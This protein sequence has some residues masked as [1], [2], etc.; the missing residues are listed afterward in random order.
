MATFETIKAKL[1]T[2]LNSA[3]QTTGEDK[4]TLT[5]AVARL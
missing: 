3:N 5:E 2:I 4:G 1:E